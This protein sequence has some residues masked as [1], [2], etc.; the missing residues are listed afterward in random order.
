MEPVEAE[1]IM[2]WEARANGCL[3]GI[4][5]VKH[6]VTTEALDAARKLVYHKA[7]AQGLA[8]IPA[9]HI[10]RMGPPVVTEDEVLLKELDIIDDDIDA[11]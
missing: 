2:V 6:Q 11:I 5:P 7:F 9:T 8:W 3:M 10:R 4:E 1:H